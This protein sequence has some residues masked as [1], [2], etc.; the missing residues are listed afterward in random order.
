MVSGRTQTQTIGGHNTYLP[1]FVGSQSF[2]LMKISPSTSKFTKPTG[3]R[4]GFS[5]GHTV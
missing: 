3:K 2:F 1:D 5:S 4:R